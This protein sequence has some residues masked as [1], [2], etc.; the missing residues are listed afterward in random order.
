MVILNFLDNRKIRSIFFILSRKNILKY[1][2]KKKILL[3]KK[4]K[5][6]VCV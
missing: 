3:V 5:L 6:C 1:Q 2:N 4:K